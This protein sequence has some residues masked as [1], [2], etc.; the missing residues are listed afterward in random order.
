MGD[1]QR[2]P[3]HDLAYA[4]CIYSGIRKAIDFE[5]KH[6]TEDL[7]EEL[8]YIVDRYRF[9]QAAPGT[10]LAVKLD[11]YLKIADKRY[12]ATATKEKG[13]V[14]ENADEQANEILEHLQSV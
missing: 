6:G 14:I 11:K 4:S 7:R 1:F 12:G 3:Q 2:K 9:E 10:F 5:I 13:E 8:T